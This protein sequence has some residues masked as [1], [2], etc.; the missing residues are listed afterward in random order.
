MASPVD[1]STKK[2]MKVKF[3]AAGKKLLLNLKELEQ[4]SKKEVATS[5]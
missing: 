4:R 5:C 3:V 2:I 1:F